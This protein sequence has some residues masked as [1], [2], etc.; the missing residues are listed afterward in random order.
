MLTTNDRQNFFSLKLGQNWQS[1][2][3]FRTEGIKALENIKNGVVAT[4]TTKTGQYRIVEER[5]FQEMYGLA[6][7]VER[8]RGGLR[9]VTVAIR[10]AQKH[11]DPETLE[12]LAEA[13]ALLGDLPEL[14]TRNKFD[15]LLPEDIALD[16]EDEVT[17]DYG[18]IL[19]PFAEKVLEAEN[20]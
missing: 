1:F 5:D 2:E 6:R 19:R 11:P 12:V 9:L 18:E 3:K 4:L 20:R 8:L 7:D 10:A 15:P 16:D 14:P 17:L 13:V